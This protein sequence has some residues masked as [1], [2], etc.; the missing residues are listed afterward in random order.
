M[1]STNQVL[2]VILVTDDHDAHREQILRLLAEEKSLLVREATSRDALVAMLKG[3]EYDCVVVDALVAGE[4][5]F[6]IKDSLKTQFRDLPAIVMMAGGVPEQIVVKA[7]RSGFDDFVRKQSLNGPELIH[8]VYR[9]AERRCAERQRDAEI[10]HLSR[11]A[12][13]DRLTGLPNRAFLEDRLSMLVASSDR[14]GG[15]FA[16]LL[17]DLNEFRT[18]NDTFGHSVGDRILLYFAQHLSQV[19]RSSDSFGRFGSDEF[20][21]LMDRQVSAETVKLACERL[22]AALS[23]SIDLESVGMTLSATIGAAIY[24]DD[25]ETLPAVLDAARRALDL[26]R[27][28]GRNYALASELQGLSAEGAAPEPGERRTQMGMP[29]G[30]DMIVALTTAAPAPSIVSPAAGDAG[31]LVH[32]DGALPSPVPLAPATQVEKIHR[33]EN[34]RSERRHRVLKRG[35][36]VLNDGFS[37]VDCMIRDLSPHGARITVHIG[38]V[39][40]RGISLRIVETGEVLS[41]ESRWQRGQDIGLRFIEGRAHEVVRN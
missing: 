16:V 41:A 25:G 26:A 28:S 14:H 1:R 36:I 29:L 17:I 33:D 15:G 11:L 34:R 9:A 8:A 20:L 22:T 31:A 5:S 12:M 10:E 2:R 13:R 21:Y 4:S 18:I 38:Y 32:A 27:A 7:F 39:A 35:T 23:F 30:E 37:T 19:A 40:P 3:D 24:S 6:A